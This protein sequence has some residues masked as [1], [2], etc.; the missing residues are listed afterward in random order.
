M[1]KFEFLN[2]TA[3]RSVAIATFSP[4]ARRR[5]LRKMRLRKML[6]MSPCRMPRPPP[7][8]RPSRSFSRTRRPPAIDRRH[9]LAHPAAQ[10]GMHRS[11]H[12][13][14]RRRILPDRHT[15]VGDT[16]NELPA[17][18]TPSASRTRPASSAPPVST[19]SICAA[20]ARS[21]RWCWSTAAATLAADILS[22][23]VSPDINTIPTDLIERVD[24]V[25]GGN[26]AIYGSDAIAGVVNFILKEDY[27]GLAVPRPGRRQ[28]YGDAGNYYSSVLAGTNFAD[29]RGNVAINFEY[30][31]QDASSRR[32][33]RIASTPRFVTVDSISGDARHL[34]RRPSSRMLLRLIGTS[35]SPHLTAMAAQFL[36]DVPAATTGAAAR[37]CSSPTATCACK[38]AT[39]LAYLFLRQSYFIGG[40]GGTFRDGT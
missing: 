29:G 20:S 34:P 38:P 21:A 13:D 25:T 27:R 14:Q 23:A 10:S 8:P 33:G 17:L 30:A 5:P 32:A 12:L 19:C 40:D 37:I 18:R 2:A 26:S 15:S 16:L 39:A 28:Q 6:P 4:P 35:G 36:D 22:N 3:L 9:R 31:R 11:G 1:N 7:M 24:V